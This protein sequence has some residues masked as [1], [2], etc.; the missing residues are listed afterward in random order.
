MNAAIEAARAGETG[1]GF[2]EVADEVRTMESGRERTSISVEYA[3]TISKALLERAKSVGSGVIS[4]KNIA[5]ESV[6][7]EKLISE[8]N[9]QV[10]ENAQSIKSLSELM[11]QLQQSSTKINLV[12]KNYETKANLFKTT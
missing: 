7:Q 2:A 9:H 6:E 5:Q 1:R 3:D 10:G 12:T 8:M 11:E 4:S